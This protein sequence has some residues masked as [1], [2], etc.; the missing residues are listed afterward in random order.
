MEFKPEKKYIAELLSKR[1]RKF[2]I[3]EY[4]RPYKWEKSHCETLW[5]DIQ[6]VQ[7]EGGG[8]IFFRINC[9]SL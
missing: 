1:G 3:P 4:Q 5:N 8:G 9:R 2:I 6:M 7:E